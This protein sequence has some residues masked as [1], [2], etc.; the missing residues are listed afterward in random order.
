MQASRSIVLWMCA[1]ALLVGC[2]TPAPRPSGAPVDAE[3]LERWQARGR[4]GVSSAA[5]GGSGSFDWSQHADVADVQIRGPVGI[6]G[7]RLTI[8]GE[9]AQHDLELQTSDGAKLESDAAWAEL[10]SRLGASL[11]AWHFR[12]WL[13]GVAAPGAHQWL[14]APGEGGKTLEQDGWRIEYQRYAEGGA[15]LP[16]RLRAVSGATRVR[17]VID[18]WQLDR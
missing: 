10:E 7:V 17:I 9:G 15:Q 18:D 13:L 12:Y 4:I 1:L 6:G 16:T 5:G 3:H 8:K 11:P 2:A 14:P